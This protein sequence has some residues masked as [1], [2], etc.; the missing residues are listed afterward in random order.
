MPHELQTTPA[1]ERPSRHA[2]EYP[3][4]LKTHVDAFAESA[5]SYMGP[6]IDLHDM[7]GGSITATQLAANAPPRRQKDISKPWIAQAALALARRR[8]E[9]RATHNN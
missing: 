5:T 1:T 2:M 8:G 9:A 6:P 7:R 3:G 4:I